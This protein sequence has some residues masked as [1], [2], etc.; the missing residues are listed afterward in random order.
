MSDAV[1]H[2]SDQKGAAGVADQDGR[3]F[4]IGAADAAKFSNVPRPFISVTPVKE[5]PVAL[6]M[7]AIVF[8]PTCFFSSRVKFNDRFIDVHAE[9]LDHCIF[10]KVFRSERV[11]DTMGGE[12]NDVARGNERARAA[13]SDRSGRKV[14]RNDGR[15]YVGRNSVGDGEVAA[16]KWLGRYRRGRIGGCER[17]GRDRNLLRVEAFYHRSTPGSFIRA[18]WKWPRNLRGGVRGRSL[19][20]RRGYEACRVRF[21]RPSRLRSKEDRGRNSLRAAGVSL[22]FRADSP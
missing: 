16:L 22:S 21:H 14:N 12:K 17:E 7:R 6:S 20:G 10:P 8:S 4:P 19:R 3:S 15:K 2:V 1:D 9:D 13:P 11:A 18:F 5:I